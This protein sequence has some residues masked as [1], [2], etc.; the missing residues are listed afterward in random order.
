MY[1]LKHRP[2]LCASILFFLSLFVTLQLP[3]AWQTALLATAF[4]AVIAATVLYVRRRSFLPMI[5]SAFCLVACLSSV[6]YAL[7]ARKITPHLGA[8]AQVVLTVTDNSPTAETK[9]LS[10]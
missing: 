10:W 2:F 1:F 9:V 4:G 7:P 6:L 8:Q 3:L 5:F